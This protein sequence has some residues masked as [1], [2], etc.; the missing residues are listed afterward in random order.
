MAELLVS[1]QQNKQLRPVIIL[2]RN[3]HN[4]NYDDVIVCGITTNTSHP[5]YV[6]VSESDLEKG[7]LYPESGARSDLITRIIK[8]D[9]KFKV[10]KVN[11]NYH[12]KLV[13]KIVELI[14]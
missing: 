6:L 2:S 1:N 4:E 3:N 9:L 5:L 12:K 11:D 13:E 10:G 8:S 14:E 7:K